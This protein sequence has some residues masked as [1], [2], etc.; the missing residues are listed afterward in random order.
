MYKGYINKIY[1]I[2]NNKNKK[3]LTL[4]TYYRDILNSVSSMFDYEKSEKYSEIEDSTIELI[5]SNSGMIGFY[6][7]GGKV[8]TGY[9]VDGGK[10]DVNGVGEILNINQLNG[11][12][13]KGFSNIDTVYGL[14]LPLGNCDENI[15]KFSELLTETD[16]SQLCNIK[17]S[18]IS[19]IYKVKNN[20]IKQRIDEILTNN[21]NGDITSILDTDISLDGSENINTIS[22]N[23]TEHISKLQYLSAY[24]NDLLR[25]IYTF[26]GQALG[27]GMKQAQQSVE[28]I[29]SNTSASFIIPL[30]KLKERKRMCEKL[31]RIFGGKINVK[32]SKAWEIQYNKWITENME[33]E[34]GNNYAPFD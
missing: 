4:N 31:E 14:N 27:E 6:E 17:Y 10:L 13:Y 33:N 15:A 9:C 3:K 25:R 7:L 8:K 23:E 34:R 22:L 29:S 2:V 18:R 5:L 20:Q 1:D 12:H 32:F 11:E 30:A 28:E 24:H 19:P 21:T 16:V 26:Y